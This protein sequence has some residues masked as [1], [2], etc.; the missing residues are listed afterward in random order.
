M[1]QYFLK[2]VLLFFIPTILLVSVFI[3]LLSYSQSDPT[4]SI[5]RKQ[6]GLS[7]CDGVNKKRIREEL[8]MDLPVFYCSINAQAYPDTFHRIV[9]QTERDILDRFLYEYGNWNEIQTYFD[10]IKNYKKTLEAPRKDTLNQYVITELQSK[11]RRLSLQNKDSEIQHTLKYAKLLCQDSTQKLLYAGLENITQ[12][13]DNIKTHS[14]TYKNYIP[15]FRWYGSNNQYHHWLFNFLRLDFGKSYISNRPVK[16]EIK[17]YTYWTI[18]LSSISIILA[19]LIALPLGVIAAVKKGTK[20]D[21][22]INITLFGLYS[23]P[24][25]WIA[26]MFIIFGWAPAGGLP[27]FAPHISGF[28]EQFFFQLQHLILPIFCWTYPALAFLSRQMRGSML[29]VL[30]QDFIK[31][32]R[33]KGL[34]NN[35][36]IAKHVFR[37]A[38]IPIITMLGGVLPRLFA[39]SIILEYIFGIP[40]MGRYLY[41]AVLANDLPVI[42]AIVMLLSILTIIGYLISDVLYAFSDPR[43]KFK[44]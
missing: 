15:A 18:I 43:I 39:G 21:K 23:L 28:W 6:K 7:V 4:Y 8:K 10:G 41:F 35:K 31:T 34:T 36:V 25:F 32:A 37:N 5:C 20:T 2:R 22:F 44:K 14:T 38:L 24:N 26:T 11:I 17:E 3:F 33:A 30:Q 27:P 1:F 12:D 13:Y 29:Q 16:D 40:G 42:F 19:Y 9:E